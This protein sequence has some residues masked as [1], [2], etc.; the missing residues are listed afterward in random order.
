MRSLTYISSGGV[1]YGEL[2]K[3]QPHVEADLLC[4]ATDY[5]RVKARI[6]AYLAEEIVD[7]VPRLVVVRPGTIYGVRSR[8]RS[9]GLIEALI[10]NSLTHTETPIYG[11]ERAVRDF[12]FVDDVTGAVVELA[13]SD[14]RGAFNVATGVGSTPVDVASELSAI[15]GID[16]QMKILPRRPCDIE[17]NVLD[18]AKVR[19]TIPF[20][21][22]SLPDGLKRAVARVCG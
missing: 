2:K 12:V 21:P 5:G 6:E 22:V 19:S 14:A 11:G 4:P 18:I 1:V 15:L 16:A 17:A 3:S 10:A 20:N 13:L 8:D 9:F 7:V